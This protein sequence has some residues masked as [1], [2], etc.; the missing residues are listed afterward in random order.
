MTKKKQE[1]KNS[2]LRSFSEEARKSIVR[3]IEA[4][5]TKAE[6]CRRYDVCYTTLYRWFDK[7]SKGY[8]RQQRTILETKEQANSYKALQAEL[9][10]AYE[11]LG[12]SQKEVV[13][14]SKLIDLVSE[15][16]GIDLKKNFGTRL[17]NNSD[18]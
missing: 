15:E 9:N 8:R 13:F 4:G 3:E 18:Q 5:L 14:L 17:S 12:R 16:Y 2:K 10:K 7:Y 1:S 11:L 6:A